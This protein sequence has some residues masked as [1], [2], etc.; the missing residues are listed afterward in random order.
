MNINEYLSAIQPHYEGYQELHVH[1]TGSYRD[2]V[3]TVPEVFDYAES[4]GRQA[5]SITDHGNFTRLFAA[6]QERTTREKNLLSKLMEEAPKEDLDN[7]LKILNDFGS[8]RHPDD[9]LIPYIEKYGEIFVE[10]V[11]HTVQFV[12][13]IEMYA[14]DGP[15]D[16][17]ARHH[18][19]LYA[20]D[21]TGMKQLFKLCN[22]AQKN[23]YKDAPQVTFETLERFA[24]PGTAGHG[25]IIATSACVSGHLCKILLRPQKIKQQISALEDK[26]SSCSSV[27]EY[28]VLAVKQQIDE[29]QQKQAELRKKRSE[30]KALTKKSFDSKIEKKESKINSLYEKLKAIDG[31]KI[32]DDKKEL[33]R[34]K[35]NDDITAAQNDL[36]DLRIEKA[37]AKEKLKELPKI[38]SSISEYKSAIEAAKSALKSL[39]RAVR[40]V[41]K[42]K[43]KIA[44]LEQQLDKL[45]DV[46]SL[47]KETALHYEKIFGKGN[48]YIELQ[49]HGIKDELYCEPL[50][51]QI[52]QETGIP[53]TVANDVHYA[54]PERR[55]LRD[56]MFSMRFNEPITK[57]EQEEGS[58]EL[59]FKS[60]EQMNALFKDFPEAIQNTAAIAERCN[61]FYKKEK[62]LPKFET[63][64]SMTPGEYL[65]NF[66]R[67]NIRNKYP[68]YDL[69]SSEWKENFET[70]LSYELKIIDE[71]GYN[72]Y[73]DI[74]QDFI[75][76]ARKEKGATTVG[77][78][79]GS[80]AG[81]LVCYLLD[82][83]TVDPLKYDLLFERFLNPER[84][85]MPDID[86]DFA[87]S[88]RQDVID[89]V[90][91][92]Y[93]YKGEYD[94]DELRTTVCSIHT[95]GTLAG[96][97][98]IRAVG[99]VTEV[100]LDVCDKVAKMIPFKI[101]MTINQALEENS[102]LAELYA[103]DKV[104]HTLIDD[105]LLVEGIPDH[106]GV[107]AAG[108]IISDKPIT[109]Y[110]PMF[111]NEK[112]G[113]WVIQYEKGPCEN[114]LQLLKMD[115]LGLRNLDII[116]EA[117]DL[118]KQDKNVDLDFHMINNADDPKIF[119]N[120]YQNAHTNGVFQFEST[121]MKQILLS[122]SPKC[123][124]DVFLLNAAY[125][126]GPMQY[127]PDITKV[128]QGK[129][130]PDYIIPEMAAILDSTYGKPIYQEQIM[131]LFNK[132]AGFSLGTADII[133]RA[134]SKK[135]L[136][137]MLS[138]K[139]DFV[140][141]L[142]QKGAQEDRVQEFW[143]ELVEFAKYAFNKS[144][145]VVYS[146]VSYQTAYLKYYY[147]TEYMT[148]LLQYTENSKFAL[149]IK[150]A[151][152]MGITVRKPDINLSQSGF[153]SLNNGDILFG[154]GNI[155]NV[156]NGADAVIREREKHGEFKDIRDLTIRS[157]IFGIKKS[158][159]QTLIKAGALDSLIRNRKKYAENIDIYFDSCK[160]LIKNIKA[161]SSFN[162]E[163]LE[164]LYLQT[165][166][167]WVFPDL[168]N[169]EDYPK[170]EAL[171]FEKD[172]MGCYLSGHPLD[173][174][175]EQI[176][177]NAKENIASL[178]DNEHTVI[179]GQIRDI[180]Y[181]NRKTDNK[182]FCK[183]TF[184]DLTDS[185]DITCFT[186]NFEKYKDLIR[187]DAVVAITGTCNI[188]YSEDFDVILNKEFFIDKIAPLTVNKNM[189][190]FCNLVLYED[191]LM[192]AL[193][194]QPQ[195][196]I[197]ICIYDSFCNEIRK[198]KY[199]VSV[200][201]EMRNLLDDMDIKYVLQP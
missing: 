9:A 19:I 187:E 194:A 158:V 170:K 15:D 90:T 69:K 140:N 117:S 98:A 25:K 55:H 104:V 178:E 75:F 149:Y 195:G 183:F 5:V 137:E 41:L 188:E 101:G 77:P 67:N 159:I 179:C 130:K 28:A 20:T 49:N 128:K 87:N 201:N 30:L 119:K 199:R 23:Q 39:E 76:Y 11:R 13:G 65:E 136:S 64:N 152:D 36:N 34:Q 174:Y 26:L 82:I 147:P 198:T 129:A 135:K 134:M 112:K 175:K 29:R 60:N 141:A 50:L 83:T 54:T 197:Q 8:L 56:L 123:F 160:K 139:D 143:N 72:S 71:M 6:L 200:T 163:S 107:H 97:G 100:P 153:M 167:E 85:S 144:H 45:T 150:E 99:R 89:Y 84:V 193:E 138:Y 146:I 18:I 116:T 132:I 37:D 105:A 103:N 166:I 96:R 44:D 184:E 10:V 172:L 110:A 17:K 162:S 14:T 192:P 191:L 127:I 22:L 176:M 189:L 42:Y 91:K 80:A 151:R 70:R 93:A 79:R 118:I 3:N 58:G 156:S 124:E 186:K 109:E 52:A 74:V 190:I 7:I 21:W 53:M 131:M 40:P 126:P 73:I 121:G 57:I 125:R 180:T 182:P 164:D 114:V 133:R 173:E 115:F 185:I 169:T 59:Y 66:A 168:S 171:G 142:I 106:H 68:D 16:N 32:S 24:G 157:C 94:V 177:A 1:T 161:R 95:E 62:H 12:P 47:A 48:Y 92:R 4:L 111:W 148:A 61:V 88:I 86:T 35:I 113:I 38:E 181:F 81:S 120:I 122:F 2:G 165:N 108:I 31:K 43:A 155:K 78:G 33:Q 51:V 27:D 46:Y 196:G 63:G 154:L 102:E 145:S